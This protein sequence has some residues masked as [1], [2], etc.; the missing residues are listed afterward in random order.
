MKREQKIFINVLALFIVA[1]SIAGPVLA[2]KVADVDTS[3]KILTGAELTRVVPTSF[4]FEGQAAPTQMR[5]TAAARVNGRS[6]IAGLV[7]TSGYSA[8]VRAHYQGFFITDGAITINGESLSVG[9]YGFGF[10]NDGKFNILDIG[11]NQVLSV[12][13]TNDKALKRPRP[14]TMTMDGKN[15]RLY[16]GRDY[17]VIAFK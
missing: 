17:V 9:A 5:N 1:A 12:S 6:V 10:T 8:D 4:Y 16:A 3:D 2:Q 15:V 7:D 11:N 14:L 13:S